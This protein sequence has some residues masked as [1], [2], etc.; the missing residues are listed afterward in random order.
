MQEPHQTTLVLGLIPRFSPA[1]NA[2]KSIRA[3]F[4]VEMN[5]IAKQIKIALQENIVAPMAI[6]SRTARTLMIAP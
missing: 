5:A 3:D 6:V 2:K 1:R 4:C